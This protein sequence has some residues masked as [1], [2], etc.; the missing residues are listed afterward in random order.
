MGVFSHQ[1]VSAGSLEGI[2]PN[3]AISNSRAGVLQVPA[4]IMAFP[5]CSWQEIHRAATRSSR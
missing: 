2:D 1:D 4:G 3:K 5:S